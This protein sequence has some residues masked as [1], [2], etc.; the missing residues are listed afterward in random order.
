MV[1]LDAAGRTTILYK[2]VLGEVVT[3]IPTIGF[4]VETIDYRGKNFTVWD[5]GGCDKIRPLWRHY[6]QNT[7][8]LIFVVD[9]NDRDRFPTVRE[10]LHRMLNENELREAILLVFANK[11]DLPNALSAAEVTEGLELRQLRGRQWHVQACTATTGDGT[12]EGLDWI[13]E[14]LQRRS[15]EGSQGAG[16]GGGEGGGGGGDG[17]GGGGGNERG[18]AT[19]AGEER[20]R[21]VYSSIARAIKS[22]LP[23]AEAAGAAS[24]PKE[25]EEDSKME[26]MLTEWLSRDDEDDDIFL[27]KLTDFSLETW[28]HRTH[29]RIA[30][31]LLERHGRREGMQK[32]FAAIAAF[33]E[34]S[35][36]TKRARGTTF[37]ETMT[38]FWVHMVD[39][40][41]A[42][43]QFAPVPASKGPAAT[44]EGPPPPPPPHP[45]SPP[46][47]PPPPE[48]VDQAALARPPSASPTAGAADGASRA[49]SGVPSG[50]PSG[51]KKFLLLNPQLA[52]GGLFLHYYSKKLMLNTA[53]S[54][55][56][57]VLPDL[58]PLPSLVT[59]V[60]Q[61]KAQR[62]SGG[63]ESSE[64]F[65]SPSA[66]VT[67]SQWLQKFETRKLPS[68]GHEMRL[69]L[70]WLR[71]SR[72]ERREAVKS[73]F[74]ELG[75][76][77][78][79]GH[80]ITVTY[81]WIHMVTLCRAKAS[82]K[83][84]QLNNR[85]PKRASPPAAILPRDGA[86]ADEGQQQPQQPPASLSA[87]K[88]SAAAE[89]YD[90]FASL[91][92][93]QCLRDPR[94]IHKHYSQRTLDSD[95][96]RREFVPPDAKALPNIL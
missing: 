36:R 20:D 42:G 49:T 94:F 86:A 92:L 31:L 82:S 64:D 46:P 69:K 19:S 25:E 5:V 34:N 95:E 26:T 79:A 57:V 41:R 88:A 83:A 90:D 14:A 32:I 3:T 65:I 12:Y 73:L 93:A 21:G 59:N 28:D 10:E 62:G 2:I 29:L 27:G 1:G 84:A 80:N 35:P 71:L 13:V 48:A 16:V 44:V 15:E 76:F 52:N 91:P 72:L 17:G 18:G 74:E 87:E 38:F 67:D 43:M 4:N 70:I 78:G 54:R 37:H 11:Q 9:S 63:V 61:L 33:I 39:Y 81:F 58:R 8:V 85:S 45:P 75:Q 68:W 96:A 6:F 30:W 60:K 53:A 50:V 23:P 47:P 56:S 89:K 22:V 66:P 77:E 55:T 24:T 51:F 40:A 7:Q